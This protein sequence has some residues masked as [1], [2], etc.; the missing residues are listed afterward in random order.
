MN[1][2][3]Q[4]MHASAICC[5]FK[6]RFHHTK[7]L[8]NPATLIEATAYQLSQITQAVSAHLWRLCTVVSVYF[9]FHSQ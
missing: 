5:G 1:V 2:C 8:E 4:Y 3:S 7:K 9:H 6:A